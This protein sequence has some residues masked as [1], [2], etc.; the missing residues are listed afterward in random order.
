MSARARWTVTRLPTTPRTSRSPRGGR[1]PR[2]TADVGR[3][4]AV[5]RR[6]GVPLTCAP[7]APACRAG[8]DRRD[9]RRRP[10]GLPRDR[11]PRRRGASPVGPGRRC[12]G[13][14][15]GWRARPQARTRPGSEGACT[16]GGVVANNSSGMACGTVANTYRTLDSLV[17]VLPTARSSTP[18]PPMPT[19]AA[20]R[21]PELSA[22]LR[23]CATGCATTRTEDDRT[24]FSMKNTMG[25]A[26]T[27]CST[28]TAGRH[29]RPPGRRQRGHA[30]FRLG[31]QCAPC[32]SA[33]PHRPAGVRRPGR[34]Q[35]GAALARGLRPG[36]HRVAGRGVVAGRA[37][38]AR[39]AAAGATVATARGA[40]RRIPPATA[41]EAERWPG[42]R[43]R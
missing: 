41:E 5:S 21:E 11:G 16:I 18:V 36:D 15:P 22:G 24:Q 17:L 39:R 3:L 37:G 10:E 12:V 34:R 26:S 23:G 43:R 19:P 27:R 25:T 31:R 40:A 4:F 33:H 8:R 29:P 30:R 14:M 28:T 9:P 7:G 2:D 20:R 1:H 13:S 32:R 38:D 35:P 6:Q 42:P